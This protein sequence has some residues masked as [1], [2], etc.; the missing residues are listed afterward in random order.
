MGWYNLLELIVRV[1]ALVNVFTPIIRFTWFVLFWCCLQVLTFSI[2]T[3]IAGGGRGGRVL[4]CHMCAHKIN[5]NCVRLPG[6]ELVKSEG[7]ELITLGL[8]GPV[9]HPML[10]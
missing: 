8:T 5:K 4:I 2:M 9:G 1:I 3:S 10:M 6:N 7:K